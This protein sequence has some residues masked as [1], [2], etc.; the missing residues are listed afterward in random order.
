MSPV[1]P[2]WSLQGRVLIHKPDIAVIMETRVDPGRLRNTLRLLGFNGYC[3]SQVHGFAGGIVV[4]WREDN[5]TL[6]VLHT[7]FQFIHI[8]VLIAGI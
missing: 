7:T 4:A 2:L 8:E 5:I 1:W 3:F 6:R